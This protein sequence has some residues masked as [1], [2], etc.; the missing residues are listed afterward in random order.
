MVKGCSTAAMLLAASGTVVSR[1]RYAVVGRE[2]QAT[3]LNTRL[4][5]AERLPALAVT[6][7]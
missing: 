2:G 1:P 7:N 6:R 4:L 5:L 3:P